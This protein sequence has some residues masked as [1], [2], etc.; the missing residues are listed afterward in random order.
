VKEIAALHRGRAQLRNHPDGGAEAL[1][2]VPV[3][4]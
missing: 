1:L 4:A 2:V 3:R